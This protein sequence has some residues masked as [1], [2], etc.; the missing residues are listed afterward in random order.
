MMRE[1]TEA[2]RVLAVV[3]AVTALSSCSYTAN[4]DFTRPSTPVEATLY[5]LV[6]GPVD[7]PSAFNLVSGYG[8]GVP[9]TV[10]VDQVPTW[11]VAFAVQDGTPVWVPRGYFKGFTASA[12][13][14][15]VDQAFEEVTEAPSDAS[16]YD[17]TTP[18]PVKD[19]GVYIIR[20]RPDESQSLPCRLFA[21]VEV[22]SIE[23][24]PPRIQFRYLWNPN[25]GNRNLTPGAENP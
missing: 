21:K 5:D 22:Q 11:D 2:W 4:F 16:L 18:T 7:R 6:A 9:S 19:G 12:G 14:L 8:S 20:S 25:C 10:R 23:G 3:V 17:E 24:D 13:V 1:L 15:A